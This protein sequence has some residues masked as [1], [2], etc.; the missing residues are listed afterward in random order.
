MKSG[1]HYGLGLDYYTKAIERIC[2]LVPNPKFYVFTN[3]LDWTKEH[4]KLN[5]RMVF[6]D[7]S[8]FKDADLFDFH[9]M[10]QC[11]NNIIANSTFSWWAAWLNEYAEKRV[12]APSKWYNGRSNILA[13]KLLPNTWEII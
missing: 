12:V 1:Y 4:L 7:H 5:H 6:V 11:K 8:T 13:T 2:S 3:D 9:L 10:S